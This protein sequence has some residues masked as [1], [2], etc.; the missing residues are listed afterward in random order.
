M[1][2]EADAICG[3]A[4]GERS[5]ERTNTRNGYRHRDWDTRAG[6]STRDP[7]AALRV[8]LPG[9]A[10][11]APPPGRGGAGH[12]SSPRPICS[13]SRTRRME[14]LVETL[15]I[16]RLSK[17]QVCEM[18]KDLDAQVGGVPHP[19][20]GCRALHVR[21]RRRSGAQGPRGR[22]DRQRPRAARDR[23]QR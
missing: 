13:G 20:A 7:E 18:A 23:G 15:G 16:A 5:E 10:A 21:G 9:L 4:Y 3:A 22:P 14:K 19:A 1:G 11:G 6:T 8:L 12:A 2:A 17:S